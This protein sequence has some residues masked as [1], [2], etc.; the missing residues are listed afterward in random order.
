MMIKSSSRKTR[1]KIGKDYQRSFSKKLYRKSNHINKEISRK[2]AGSIVDFVKIHG[3]AVIVFEN[4]SGWKAKGGKK[5]TVTRQGFHLWC[6]CQI[7][8][9]VED[10][11]GELSGKVVKVN[12]RYTSKASL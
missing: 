3:V 2:V 5:C 10:R 8:S 11:W 4:L 12:P 6:H 9:L 7:I 1:A